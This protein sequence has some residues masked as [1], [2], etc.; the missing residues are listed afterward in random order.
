VCRRHHEE[1]TA[2]LQRAGVKMTRTSKRTERFARAMEGLAV[3]LWM[4][5]SALRDDRRSVSSRAR[6]QPQTPVSQKSRR[7]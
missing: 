4:L 7:A 1:I 3:W 2:A 6:R 5:A